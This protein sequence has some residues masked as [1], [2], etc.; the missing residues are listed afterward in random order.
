MRLFRP[1]LIF[2]TVAAAGARAGTLP[3]FRSDPVASLPGFVSSIAI[4]S[5][6]VIYATATS[7]KIFRIDDGDA[8]EIAALDTHAGGNGGLLGMALVDDDTAAVHYTIWDGSKI[9]DDVVSLVDLQTGEETVLHA[10]ACDIEVR[11]RGA[12][13]EHHGGNPAVAP[14]GSIFV[15][16]G[17][18]NDHHLAQDPRWNGG[19]I[20]RIRGS[21]ATQYALGLRNPYD[22]VWDPELERLVVSDNG[23]NAGDEIHI[24]TEGDN[25]GWPKT[26]GNQP[27]LAG[28]SLPR[29]VFP[30]TVAPTGILRLKTDANALLR[31]GYLLTAFASRAMYYFPDLTRDTIPD[32]YPILLDF[33]EYLID[34]AQAPNGDIYVAGASFGGTSSIHRLRVPKPGDCNGDGA[35]NSHDILSLMRELQDGD[36]HSTVTA[37]DGSYAGS[38]GCDANADSLING[39]DVTALTRMIS[40]RRAAGKR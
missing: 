34:V 19:K 16:I 2:L 35:A 11:E 12:S 32:P 25:A 20:F 6:G 13:D 24:L 8:V 5:R 39:A 10:F 30:D 31:R 22:M 3:G 17:E 38:W 15:G 4:D 18:Y 14:D 1:V 36:P 27:P 26:Y 37:Q 29:Y 9:L 21:E 28:A 40:R 7:G 23:P 33:D